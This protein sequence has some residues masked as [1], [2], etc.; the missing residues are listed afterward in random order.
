MKVLKVLGIGLI[1]IVLIWLLISLF[2]SSTVIIERSQYINSK[3]KVVFSQVNSLHI[4]SVWSYRHLIDYD[5]ESTFEGPETGVG[6]IYK[7]NSSN[8]LVGKGS[9]EIVASEPFSKVST[10]VIYEGIDPIDGEWVLE[11]AKYGNA[12]ITGRMRIDVGFM[13]RVFPGLMLDGWLGP[14]IEKSLKKLKSHCEMIPPEFNPRH[15]FMLVKVPERRV[16]VVKRTCLAADVSATLGESYAIL[17][18]EI[19][20]QGLEVAGAPFAIYVE[21]TEEKV[22]MEPGIPITNGGISRG[23]V[24]AKTI[25]PV[26][27]M[28]ID[29]HGSYDNISDVYLFIRELTARKQMEVTGPPW[30]IYVTDPGTESDTSKWLTQVFH[31]IN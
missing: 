24:I 7:W 31:P 1:L 30:E 14:E 27:A 28:Q 19:N 15:P 4:I 26:K 5:M 18:E 20:K 11:K 21:K 23:E 13:G 2:L 29:Y 3:Q 8:E 22:V 12:D 17:M 9:M 10:K 6:A 16:M 25:P